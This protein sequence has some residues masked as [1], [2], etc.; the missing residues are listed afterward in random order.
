MPLVLCAWEHYY[1]ATQKR[2]KC[3]GCGKQFS[4]KVGTIFEDSPIK[5]DK[6]LIALKLVNC[7]N[8]ISSYEGQASLE[9]SFTCFA[10]APFGF[11]ERLTCEARRKRNGS[12]SR[13]NLHW[14]SG[15]YAPRQTA[16]A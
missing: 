6:W 1:L 12:G 10:S 15:V 2:W 14:R 5:L 3:K 9:V 8:G 4:V 11:V 13:R 16:V 7:K